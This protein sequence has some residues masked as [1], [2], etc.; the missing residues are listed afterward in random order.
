[1]I[2]AD[3]HA[4]EPANLWAERIDRNICRACRASRS[5]RTASSGVSPK[6]GRA[7]VCS[8]ARLPART[9]IATPAATIRSSACAITCATASMRRSFSLTRASR[10][11][12]PPIPSSPPRSARSGTTGRGRLSGRT[13][14]ACRRWPS[15]ATADV[16]TA[17]AEIQRVAKM[18]FRGLT[19]PCKPIF[20]AHDGRHPNYNLGCTIRCG[21]RF[22][23]PTCRSPFTFRPDAIRARRAKTAAR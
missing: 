3:C 10:C 21:R 22:R 5:T 1:M 6:D 8:T 12:P 7:R 16:T 4:Q 18:G 15:I 23:T 2:S 19:L 11:G 17:T 9:S 20:G 14:I 13:T